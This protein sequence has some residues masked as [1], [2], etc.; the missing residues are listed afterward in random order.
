M[1]VVEEDTDAA[2]RAADRPR[3]AAGVSPA[4]QLA[5]EDLSG[6][7]VC[8][9][10]ELL[11]LDWQARMPAARCMARML[12][13]LKNLEARSS[14]TTS[15]RDLLAHLAENPPESPAP[16]ATQ[17]MPPIEAAP[18]AIVPDAKV[19]EPQPAIARPTRR[20][21]ATALAREIE[22]IPAFEKW[23][24]A[25]KNPTA[26]PTRDDVAFT[27][28]SIAPLRRPPREE[29]ARPSRKLRPLVAGRNPSS[30]ERQVRR[31]LSDRSSRAAAGTACRS[32]A[33]RCGAYREQNAALCRHRCG[34]PDA[35]GAALCRRAIGGQARRRGAAHRRRRVA[36]LADRRPGA[37]ANAGNRRIAARRRRGA[38]ALPARGAARIVAAAGG[39][40]AA[41][42]TVGGG[43]AA[44]GSSAAR[45]REPLAGAHRR[46][47]LRRPGRDALARL[48]DATYFVVQL[49]AV[50]TSE[51]QAAL[52]DFRAASARVLGC[53][54]T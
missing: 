26:P 18:V 36:P 1:I 10:N 39:T 30:L 54:A 44:G 38:R 31:T 25:D 35:R 2:G 47:P 11:V 45:G 8:L 49:G 13:A 27:E 42:R 50:E 14:K 21:E 22:S 43:T 19:D 53:I 40:P 52:R 41:C 34:K 28:Q 16:T 15:G 46:R 3:E 6:A 32:T 5:A 23:P 37:G 20:A 29:S 24:A 12:Q 33:A 7:G 4:L 51:A 17:V 48:A 9:P